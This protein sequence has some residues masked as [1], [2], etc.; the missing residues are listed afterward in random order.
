MINK[1]LIS[2]RLELINCWLKNLKK[3]SYLSYEEFIS[4]N[5]NS[6]AAESY[7]RRSLE[8]IF[9]IG[10][11]LLAK[12]G[13]IEMAGEYKSIAKGLASNNF[14]SNDLGKKLVQMA[15]YRNRMVHFYSM[16]TEK[17]LYDI[18]LDNL[19]DIEQFTIEIKQAILK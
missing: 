3:L 13:N 8:A 4:N 14:V 5:I 17:E 9:D 16:V 12:T 2:Q 19:G 7:L 15:G 1:T 11:H 10:R 18:L 6:A